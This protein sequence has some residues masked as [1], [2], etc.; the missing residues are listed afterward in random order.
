MIPYWLQDRLRG[1]E[2]TLALLNRCLKL[3]R[4]FLKSE[5]WEW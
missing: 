5:G 2:Q 4:H 1:K 3:G